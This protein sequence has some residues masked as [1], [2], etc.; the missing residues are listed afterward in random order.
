MNHHVSQFFMINYNSNHSDNIIGSRK[1]NFSS[2]G[3][4][5]C[6]RPC[7]Y[8]NDLHAQRFGNVI[9]THNIEG[10]IRMGYD[11]RTSVRL[12]VFWATTRDCP[13][14]NL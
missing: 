12:Y 10:N 5:H 7:R 1:I 3:A 13:Y 9:D 14:P 6:G 2:V 11:T 8:E 4:I